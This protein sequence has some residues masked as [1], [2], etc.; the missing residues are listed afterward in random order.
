MGVH[1]N[2]GID[3]FSKDDSNYGEGEIDE[4]VE[5]CIIQNF[6]VFRLNFMK[7]LAQRAKGKYGE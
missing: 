3:R 5:E 1:F 6:V 7:Q 2:E 4:V